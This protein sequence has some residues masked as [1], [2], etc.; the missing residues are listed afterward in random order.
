M[1]NVSGRSPEPDFRVIPPFQGKAGRAFQSF[2]RWLK[3]ERFHQRGQYCQDDACRICAAWRNIHRARVRPG[4]DYIFEDMRGT[5]AMTADEQIAVWPSGRFRNYCS[6]HA[7]LVAATIAH[8]QAAAARSAFQD[9]GHARGHQI[10]IDAL[11]SLVKEVVPGQFDGPPEDAKVLFDR[12][13]RQGF[14]AVIRQNQHLWGEEG[15]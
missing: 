11:W 9:E 13:V 15:I 14:L 10:A 8:N 3:N 2:T 5:C 1:C 4:C 12:A 6:P 7:A